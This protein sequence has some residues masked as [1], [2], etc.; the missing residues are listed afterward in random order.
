MSIKK[1]GNK[2]VVTDSSGKKILGT[3]SSRAKAID[4]LQAVEASKT[5]RKKGK[6]SAR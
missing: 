1:R 5:R 4:Q 2:W 6:K 3:H